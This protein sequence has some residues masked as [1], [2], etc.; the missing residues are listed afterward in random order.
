MRIADAT[1]SPEEQ[2]R[3]WRERQ[4]EEVKEPSSPPRKRSRARISTSRRSAAGS[5]SCCSARRTRQ[6]GPSSSR[7]VL[8]ASSARRERGC[9]EGTR[10]F[11]AAA[12]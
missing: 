8:G 5:P 11:R 12:R 2:M 9:R 7:C 6:V 3:K 4:R 10:K 1:G